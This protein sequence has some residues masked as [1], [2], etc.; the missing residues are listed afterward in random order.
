[1]TSRIAS[2]GREDAGLPLVSI[3]TPVL[4]RSGFVE[5]TLTSVASQ[6]Y[7]HIEHI[8]ID[9]GSTDG[10]VAILEQWGDKIRWVSEPDEGMYSAINKGLAMA[11]G[12]IMAYLN[13]DDDYFPWT[14][15]SAVRALLANP[16]VDVVFGD[17]VAVD[18]EGRQRLRLNPPFIGP[19]VLY[20][21]FLTQPA[22]FWRSH[23]YANEGGF[24]TDLKLLG[25]CDFWMRTIPNYRYHRIDEFLAIERDHTDTMRARHSAALL[26]EIELLRAQYGRRG[27]RGW[28]RRQQSRAAWFIWHRWIYVRMFL[29]RGHRWSGLFDSRRVTLNGRVVVRW[30]LRG[31]RR[32]A[33]EERIV[34]IYPPVR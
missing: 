15:G 19:Y 31:K 33:L 9:G 5:Q 11:T 26:Q 21:G 3:V 25:D 6:D 27:F 2:H 22:V 13:S 23:V 28:L 17:T 7:P 4:N 8:V 1:M 14:V 34:S 30:L 29:W 10:T 18:E 24:R 12:S 32:D 20:R 16:D